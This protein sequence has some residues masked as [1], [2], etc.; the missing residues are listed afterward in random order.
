[1]ADGLNVLELF[2][3]YVPGTVLDTANSKVK[4]KDKNI[5]PHGAYYILMKFQF[6]DFAGF[7]RL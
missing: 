7:I 5:H 1:M 2:I 4:K 3:Q 6:Q